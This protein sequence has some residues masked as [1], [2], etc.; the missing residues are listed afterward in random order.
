MADLPSLGRGLHGL[1]YPGGVLRLDPAD[2]INAGLLGFWV[3]GLGPWDFSGRNNPLAFGNSP[4]AITGKLGIGRS[5][6]GSNQYAQTANAIN[7]TAYTAITLSFWMYQPSFN[8][9]DELAFETSTNYNSN[10]GAFIVDPNNSTTF[11]FSGGIVFGAY[12]GSNYNLYGFSRPAAGVWHHYLLAMYITG[13]QDIAYVDGV[14][15]SLTLLRNG[16]TT[17]FGN[18]VLYMMSRAGSSLFNSGYLECVRLYNRIL[19]AGEA[20]R[21]YADPWGGL[22]FPQDRVAAQLAGQLSLAWLS[23]RR[24]SRTY[25]IR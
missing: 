23:Y 9:S 21:L 11:G 20:W 15:Q 10:I 1:V 2:P 7:L 25:L 5:F 17:S 6:N 4:P 16:G 19:T 24:P 18:F 22:L 8:N 13:T 14:P 3:P 12:T